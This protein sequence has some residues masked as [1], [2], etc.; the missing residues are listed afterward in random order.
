MNFLI[1]T[2]LRIGEAVCL[3]KEDI[4]LDGLKGYIKRKYTKTSAGARWFYFHKSLIKNISTL[5]KREK[6][7]PLTIR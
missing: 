2:G 7:F 5:Q 3:R 4:C 1:S 6:L